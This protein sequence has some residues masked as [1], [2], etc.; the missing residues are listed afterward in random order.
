MNFLI[1]RSRPFT[2]EIRKNFLPDLSKG[3]KNDT[4]S[5]VENFSNE[6]DAQ[7]SPVKVDDI[8]VP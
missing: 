1:G 3:Q 2:P 5:T 7:D 8:V 6:N 4:N